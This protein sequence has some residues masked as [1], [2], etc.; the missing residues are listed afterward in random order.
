M[1]RSGDPQVPPGFA[2]DAE[3]RR[4]CGLEKATTEAAS[5]ETRDLELDQPIV[6]TGTYWWNHSTLKALFSS[7]HGGPDFVWGFDAALDRAQSMSAGL[8]A[9]SSR[10]S[11]EQE[12][13]ARD[14]RV[15]L[16]RIEDGFLRSIG[17]GA[18]FVTAASLAVDSRGIYYDAS[19]PS[20]LEHLLETAD[21][22]PLEIEEGARIRK[23]I[24]G[25]RL[26]KYNLRA[27]GS[28][29]AF[30][31]GKTVV[32]VPGQVADDASILRTAS[33]TIDATSSRE[34]VNAQLLRCA[35]ERHPDAFIVYKPHPDVV[36][37]LR[38]GHV[39]TDITERLADAVL[40]DADILALIE[41]ADHIETI[42]SLA[43]FEA[44]LRGKSVTTHG[45]PFYA[46]W[47]I[48]QDLTACTRR[49][50]KRSIDEMT[51]IAFTRYTRHMN[52]YTGKAC[53]VHELIEALVCQRTDRR[54][55]MRNAVLKRVAWLVERFKSK[56]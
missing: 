44:L 20:D 22:S 46:G 28:G 26:S 21:L 15:P 36:S 3:R 1:N 25:A 55:H 11:S 41:R 27:K 33:A 10:L 4:A 18:G 7:R 48:S 37:G 13:L 34:N 51:T 43:G 12:A 16:F 6:V 39:P 31:Q 42:S 56:K 14:A 30:P 2:D 47:G 32:L 54:H 17:L 5:G 9:W 45:L 38:V 52:P 24:L 53:T 19:R 29:L 8:V 50:R 35:R 40:P 23:A 49:S